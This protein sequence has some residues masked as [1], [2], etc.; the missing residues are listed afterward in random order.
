MPF[1]P[2]GPCPGTSDCE[3]HFALASVLQTA[4]GEGEGQLA[5]MQTDR[6]RQTRHR[7]TRQRENM[8]P[9]PPGTSRLQRLG[10]AA[11][12]V[13]PRT[14]LEFVLALVPRWRRSWRRCSRAGYSLASGQ[15]ESQACLLGSVWSPAFGPPIE[16]HTQHC[17][18][19]VFV[20]LSPE[21]MLSFLR[22]CPRPK[23]FSVLHH[24]G[25]P[26]RIHHK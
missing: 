20:W 17:T 2:C 8:L 25:H 16:A 11:P 10:W 26:I 22:H 12:W 6:Q 7:Q 3:S 15:Q 13:L 1:G 4:K 21:S 19:F 23:L 24:V 5:Y 18:A 14:M 9:R